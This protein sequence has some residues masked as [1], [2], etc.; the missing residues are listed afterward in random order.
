MGRYYHGDIEGKFWFA[1]QSSMA[2]QRFGGDMLEPQYVDFY[3]DEDH[4]PKI[5]KELIRIETKLGDRLKK[6]HDFFTTNN[7]YDSQMLKDNDILES[8][9]ED[10]ADYKLGIQIKECVQAQ[11]SCNFQAEL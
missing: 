5:M 8:D 9:L 1:V 3:F 7:G 10:Y 4:L 11:G 6:M 2:P